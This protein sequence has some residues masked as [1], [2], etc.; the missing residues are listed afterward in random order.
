MARFDRR[1]MA[2]RALIIECHDKFFVFS[3]YRFS[4]RQGNTSFDITS[5]RRTIR[6]L[7]TTAEKLT[8][9]VAK[10]ATVKIEMDIL[11]IEARKR[12]AARAAA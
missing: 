8:E 5:A 7:R 6:L 10:C 11:S 4:K 9:D 3:K 1:P 12:V 2:V